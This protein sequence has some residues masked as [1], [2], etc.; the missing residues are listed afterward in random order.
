MR[1]PPDTERCQVERLEGSFMTL[2]PRRMV[3]C[4]RA[5]TVVVK[6]VQTDAKDGERG[7][8]SMC[9]QC[10]DVFRK[11]VAGTGTFAALYEVTNLATGIVEESPRGIHVADEEGV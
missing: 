10:L 3:R 7:S 5:P 1:I 11:V 4:D 6:E 9:D 8:M 2:G